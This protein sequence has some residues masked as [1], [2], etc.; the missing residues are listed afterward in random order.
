M[1]NV[2][3]FITAI[4]FV[5][6]IS[7]CFAV[8]A[9]RA[10]GP[11]EWAAKKVGKKIEDKLT[12]KSR[13]KKEKEEQKKKAE[14]DAAA[15]KKADEAYAAKLKKDAEEKAAW[16]ADKKAKGE[17]PHMTKD[18]IKRRKIGRQWIVY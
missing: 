3:V 10:D 6:V 14:A 1:K 7:F 2:I 13:A 17:S 4:L 12:A 16:I 5:F 11:V 8:N 18:E 15:Q 9:A